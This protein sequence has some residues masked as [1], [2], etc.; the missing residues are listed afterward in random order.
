MGI[1]HPRK[2]V[3]RSDGFSESGGIGRF[4]ERETLSPCDPIA[5]RECSVLRHFMAQFAYLGCSV[6]ASSASESLFVSIAFG[7][8]AA[9]SLA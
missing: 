4:Y 1:L 3:E 2:S 8:I 7:Y 6:L 5:E 9:I